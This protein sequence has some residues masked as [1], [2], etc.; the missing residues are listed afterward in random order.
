MLLGALPGIKCEARRASACPF[1]RAGAVVKLVLRFGRG[2]MWLG[3]SAPLGCW[4]RQPTGS[5]S[6]FVVRHPA[7]NQARSAPGERLPV[8]SGWRFGDVGAEVRARSDVA[9]IKC[10]ARRLMRHPTGRRAP[11]VAMY[12][13]FPGELVAL[14]GGMVGHGI[15]HNTPVQ[16]A[17]MV[18]Q[19]RINVK[20]S[21]EKH[22]GAFF[23]P[24]FRPV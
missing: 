24:S 23:R 2:V 18:R 21:P 11:S 16:F 13:A 7:R 17:M 22:A 15:Q 9:S 14:H 8:P 20:N 10:F 5:L 6:P 4:M 19:N 1:G 3:L 12:P